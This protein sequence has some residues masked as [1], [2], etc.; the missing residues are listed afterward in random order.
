MLDFFAGL[1]SSLVLGI[2]TPLTAVCVIPLYPGF[3]AFLSNQTGGDGTRRPPLLLGAMVT[4]GVISFMSLLGLLFTTILEVSL[5]AVVSIVSPIAFGILLV[6]GSL[7]IFDFDMGKIFPKFQSPTSKNPM[8]SAFLFGFFFGAIVLP[9][10]PG[11]IAAMFSKTLATS[12]IGFIGNI[13]NFI[14][15]GI[16]MATPLLVFAGISGVKS[17]RI[18]SFLIKHKTIINRMTGVTLVGISIYYLLFVFRVLG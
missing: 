5:T 4:L 9:C 6:I 15:F 12:T 10:N 3:L 17:Q 1:A 11:L 8:W 18:I 7:M 16:G 2:L 14:V 13:T